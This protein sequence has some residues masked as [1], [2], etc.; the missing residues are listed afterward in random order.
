MKLA[1]SNIAWE[2]DQ[3]E[4]LLLNFRQHGI[5]GIEVAPTKIWPSW[6][7]ASEKAAISYRQDLLAKGFVIPALQALLFGRPDLQIFKPE[8]HGTFFEHIKLLADIAAGMGARV[9]VWGSPRNRQRNQL[10]MFE[11]YD[12]AADFFTKAAEICA[13]RDVCIGIESNPVNYLCDFITNV[14]DARRLVDKIKHKAF[15]LHVD[16][17]GIHLCGGDAETV[18][19]KAGRFVHFHASEPDLAPLV[20]GVVDHASACAVLEQLKY[21]EWV[22][23]EMKRPENPLA[24]IQSVQMAAA[25]YKATDIK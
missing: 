19:K 25:A 18:L 22:S 20:G 8:T 15:Q 23:I 5:T 6:K 10:D 7:G 12:K 21:A 24:I 17:G 3:E 2:Q 14:A 13:A 4:N 9:L 16:M 1:I 11:A